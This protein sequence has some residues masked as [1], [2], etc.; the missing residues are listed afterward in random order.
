MPI[1]TSEIKFY[2]SSGDAVSSTNTN[3]NNSLG[4]LITTTEIVSDTAQN[5]FDN[6]SGTESLN[7]VTGEYRCFFIK[8]TNG[9]GLTLENARIWFSSGT[10]GNVT[11]S[12]DDD[13]D[14][15]LSTRAVGTSA[16]PVTTAYTAPNHSPDPQISFS[17]PTS[18]ATALPIGNIPPGQHKAIWLRRSV[19][20]GAGAYS[21]NSFSF[22]VEGE[23]Q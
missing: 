18:S 22:T 16:E 2:L 23:S 17:K 9:T 4:G 20:A 21:N 1:A 6:V 10:T 8:N 19:N 13:V 11:A 12:G 7:G 3:P 14:M 15:A 5:L